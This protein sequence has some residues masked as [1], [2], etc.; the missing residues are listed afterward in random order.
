VPDEI[1][2]DVSS[3]AS[4]DS[5]SLF[6]QNFDKSVTTVDDV[7]TLAFSYPAALDGTYQFSLFVTAT[8]TADKLI[9]AST[10]GGAFKRIAGVCSG[11]GAGDGYI[12]GSEQDAGVSVYGTRLVGDGSNMRFEVKGYVAE[13][14]VWRLRLSIG[15]PVP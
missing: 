15:V 11:M 1:T 5:F 10:G 13:T 6:D 14:F 7:F 12:R 8:R 3:E 9:F 4:G 2:V